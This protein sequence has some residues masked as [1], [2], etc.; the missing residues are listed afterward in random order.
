MADMVWLA[1]Y[2]KSGNT[3]LRVLLA[4]YQHD[5]PAPIDINAIDVSLMAST[6]LWFDEWVG[7]EASALDDDTIDTLRPGVYR[8]MAGARSERQFVKTHDCW[9]RVASGEP[10]FPADV[11]HGV[12][13][14]LRNPLDVV[15]SLANHYG[16]SADEALTMLCSEESQLA[17]STGQLAPQLRQRLG[18]WSSH[19]GSWLDQSRLPALVV[20][21]ED[22]KADT[23]GWLTRVL[24]FCEVEVD[25]AR[26]AKAVAFSS[27]EEMQ[28]QERAGGFRK[29]L[30][31]NTGTFFRRGRSGGW[32]EELT[33]EQVAR[34]IAAHGPMMQR[35]GY[36]DAAGQPR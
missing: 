12:V 17:R 9:S 4:N 27:F 13:Y 15:A 1:S 22:L 10:M 6:R 34:L 2:P 16:Q 3:W 25:T 21:Y 5:G 32:R 33:A 35:F 7:I 28:R 26:V 30:A 20:R 31:V 14:A 29:R 18:C 19:A 11:T 24:E 8:C 23:A 36:L